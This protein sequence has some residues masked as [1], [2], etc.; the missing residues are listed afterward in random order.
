MSRVYKQMARTCSA[1]TP[2]STPTPAALSPLHQSTPMASWRVF[3]DQLCEEKNLMPGLQVGLYNILT[4]GCCTGQCKCSTFPSVR[5]VLLDSA[6]QAL[7][8]AFLMVYITCPSALCTSCSW[9][10]SFNL[11]WVCFFGKTTSQIMSCSSIRRHI[12]TACLSYEWLL[13]ISNRSIISLEIAK[14]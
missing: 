11:L 9:I 2:P 6:G 14:Q 13:M 7:L 1:P 12:V 5:K 10:W 4:N 3:Y 8:T